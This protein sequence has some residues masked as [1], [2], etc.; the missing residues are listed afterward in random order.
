MII[1]YIIFCL[2][3]LNIGPTNVFN[4]D[5]LVGDISL[6]Y[7]RTLVLSENEKHGTEMLHLLEDFMAPLRLSSGK[8]KVKIG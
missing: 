3:I 4:Y 5:P 1:F 6:Q 2:S 8:I 7:N